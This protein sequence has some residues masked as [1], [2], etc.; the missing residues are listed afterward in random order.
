MRFA[1]RGPTWRRKK[2]KG[3]YKAK[4]V[5]LKNKPE[6]IK[7]TKMR[8]IKNEPGKI[9]KLE[10]IEAISSGKTKPKRF[11]NKCENI[12]K[13]KMPQKKAWEELKEPGETRKPAEHEKK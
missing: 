10:D 11:K 5:K 1:T 6:R 13:N 4:P 8:G 9:K 12:H 3:D 2:K 7:K